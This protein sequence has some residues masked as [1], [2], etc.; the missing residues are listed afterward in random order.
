MIK[1][2]EII[3]F[4]NIKHLTLDLDRVAII[5]GQ[6]NLGKSNSLNALN[7]LVTN[8]LLTDK[9]G[10]GESDIMSIIP[11]DHRK[12][13]HTEVSIWLDS[14][15]KFTKVYKRSYDKYTNKVIKHETEYLINDA[16]CGTQTEFYNSLYIAFGFNPKFTSLKIEEQRLFT[17]PLYALLKLDYKELRKLL[18]ALGCSVSNEELYNLGFRDLEPYEK[19]YMGKWDVM[20]KNL[21]DNIKN[22]NI[23]ITTLEN[24]L[25]LYNDVVEP[26][27]TKLNDLQNQK[28]AL[29]TEL[30]EVKTKNTRSMVE[31]IK[32]QITKLN[33]NLDLKRNSLK[34]EYQAKI[35]ALMQDKVN[36]STN[37]EKTK[38][39]TLKCFIEPINDLRNE[40]IMKK[41]NLAD[42]NLGIGKHQNNLSTYNYKSKSLEMEKNNLSDRLGK[43]INEKDE[44]ICP[45]CGSPIQLNKEAHEQEI[46][47]LTDRLNQIDVDLEQLDQQK[48]DT[49]Q[50]IENL[51]VEKK[52]LEESI[53]ADQL[54]LS[55]KEL[56]KANAEKEL[57]EK[58][59]QDNQEKEIQDQI[60]E[61]EEKVRNINDEFE[62]EMKA[63]DSLVEK[64][65][66]IIL[67]SQK[68]V[69]EQVEIINQKITALDEEIK[70]EYILKNDYDLKCEKEKSIQEF[71]QKLNDEEALLGRLN[72][73]I[74][75]MCQLI[76]DKAKEITGFNFIMLEQNLTNDGIT[77]TCYV[78]DDNNVPYKDINTARKVEM[79]INFIDVVRKQNPNNLPIMVD[80][81]EGI[82]H[83]EK[84]SK[85]TD[86]QLICT[87]VSTDT[88]LNVINTI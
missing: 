57:C 73:F 11:I 3:N 44:M 38:F 78:V 86:K 64:K 75:K 66:N 65:N 7:W 9:Y 74:Q 26:D 88:N 48:E 50:L 35:N 54:R 42:L 72:E 25:A 87:R 19:Q 71:I 8:K 51:Q 76:N 6:N 63:I 41:S 81:L 28:T 17:D 47:E 82:D 58:I 29:I 55:A 49:L 30:N 85:F 14:G 80:R 59:S 40:L 1:K 61:L 37:L 4:R 20:R 33:N 56:A 13:E 2:L 16:K 12:G 24:Q 70:N 52:T 23:D 84:I 15:T 69:N 32:N 43:A 5:T 18:V 60:L 77:E 83:I 39:D 31:D 68:A 10:E 67:D 45:V 62:A 27:S 34:L 53:S 21:K 36:I 46:A 79:G 22:L